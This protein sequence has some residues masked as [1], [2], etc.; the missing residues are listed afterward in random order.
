[1]L[2]LCVQQVLA[3]QTPL[4][5]QTN[6][7]FLIYRVGPAPSFSVTGDILALGQV[8]FVKGGWFAVPFPPGLGLGALL[9]LCPGDVLPLAETTNC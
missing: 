7:H 2:P 5:S 6:F 3:G 4:P 1:M 8:F 9:S